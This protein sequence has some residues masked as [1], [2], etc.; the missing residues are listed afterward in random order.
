M[1]M[2]VVGVVIRA[3]AKVGQGIEVEHEELSVARRKLA[4]P[5]Q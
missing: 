5:Q 2:V 3:L 4:R 1:T